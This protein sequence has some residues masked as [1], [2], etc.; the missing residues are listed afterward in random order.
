MEG[1]GFQWGLT[2]Y[3]SRRIC[4]AV[5]DSEGKPFPN[6]TSTLKKLFSVEVGLIEEFSQ[7]RYQNVISSFL[8]SSGC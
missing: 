2:D 7:K 8:Y 3:V 6:P 5:K 1:D 4:I